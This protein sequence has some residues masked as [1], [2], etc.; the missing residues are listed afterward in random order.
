MSREAGCAATEGT[1][2]MAA[3]IAEEKAAVDAESASSEAMAVEQAKTAEQKAS[4][5]LEPLS[6]GEACRAQGSVRANA[7]C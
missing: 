4:A 2:E 5:M 7:C 1:A 3:R 6:R